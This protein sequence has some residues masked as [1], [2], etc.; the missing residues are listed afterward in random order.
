MSRFQRQQ[1]LDI[2]KSLHMLHEKIENRLNV[3]DYETVQGVLADCQEAAIQIGETIEQIEGTETEAVARLEQYC[4]NVYQISVQIQKISA[5]KA[6][7]FL[8]G[9]LIKA[10]NDI[11]HMPA[12]LEAVFLPYKVSMWDSLESVWKAADADPN[13][14]AY[15]IPI[16]YYDKNKDGSFG[17]EHYEG[18]QFPDYVSVTHYNDYDFK[19]RQPDM[20]FIHNPYDQY[21]KVTSVHPFFYS[22]NLK[23]FTDCLVYIPYYCVSGKMNEA[24]SQCVAYYYADYII[25]QAEKYR[26]CFDSDL[27]QEK[28]QSLGSPKFDKVIRLCNNPPEPPAEW[29]EKMAGKRVYFYNTSITGM[30]AN[31][32]VFLKKMA[33]V[34]QCFAD[35]ESACLLWRPHPLLE[36]TFDSMRAEYKTVYERLKQY[37][38]D[39]GIGIYDDT[40]EI[41]TTIAHSD[42]YIG[43][44]GTSVTALFGV[45]GK[46]VFI[47]NN[48]IDS[49][50]QED[51]WRGE[52]IKNVSFELYANDEWMVTQ[53]NKLYHASNNGHKY[54]YYCDL[55]D[56]TN[57]R[58]YSSVVSVKGKAY[59]CP[60]VAQDILVIGDRKIERK[61]E[62]R[63]YIEQGNA[64]RDAVR[65]GEFLFLIP[66]YYP[67]VVRYGATSDEVE[68]IEEHMDILA[69]TV[70]GEQR[71]GGYCVHNGY[72]YFA[73]PIDN[74]VLVIRTETME[75]QVLT[76]N[77]ENYGGCYGIESDGIDLWVFP[78]DGT[79]VVRWNPDSGETQEY[80]GYPENLQCRHPVLGY[81]CTQKPFISITFC[82]D[83][84][85]LSPEY[86]NMF[87]VINKKTGEMKEWKPP[88][89]QNKMKRN[90]YYPLIGKIYYSFLEDESGRRNV[91][92]ISKSDNRIYDVNLTTGK[93]KELEIEFNMEDL[94]DHEPG[95]WEHSGRLPYACHENAFNSLPVFLE[96]K[97]FG[98]Q[99]DRNRAIKAYGEIAANIDGTS[100]A[101][102]YQFAHDKCGM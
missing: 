95:F 24:Q 94:C 17:T 35:C 49:V 8:E 23:Q 7:K 15:V 32:E 18:D 29:K 1:I 14:D 65:Y 86:A 31:T 44:A 41:E 87:I 20:V 28:L 92:L 99:F 97:I 75:T 50:P 82:G 53:G 98:R 85:Y 80:A 21:N 58:Y 90:G 27:P 2:I 93:Y 67:A 36:S 79:T 88:I 6:Y 10:E 100:G 26:K 56:Y 48:N 84:A 63:H 83:Y 76:I 60:I 78:Y 64:F 68:Y 54:E 91:R 5:H 57:G 77:A 37:F 71:Y 3:R 19:N 51:D 12:K 55:P 45:V 30:L 42:A 69:G 25:I 43:D 102:I 47:L 62:L 16:P 34:F 61:I 4:E 66:Q 96:N 38:F 9:S 89:V 39:S 52:I 13:C 33:Y 11:K 72:L 46:P 101:K 73:S 81:E 40:P 22:N 74:R 59:V 70:H